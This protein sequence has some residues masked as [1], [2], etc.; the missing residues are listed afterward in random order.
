MGQTIVVKATFLLA[1]GTATLAPEQE[2]ANETDGHWKG[3]SSRSV[4]RPS[5]KV[6]YKPRAEVMLVGHAYAPKKQ[7]VRSLMTR[8]TVGEVDKS[9]EVWCDRV[10]RSQG[11]QLLEGARFTKMPLKWERAAGGPDTNN[12]VGMRFDAAPDAYGAVA[13]PNLQPPG[14]LVSGRSDSF[15]SI[16]FAPIAETWS[17]RTQKLARLAGKFPVPGWEEH[18]LP[19]G[20]DPSF[21]QAAPLDQQ[22]AEIRPNERI[23]LENLHPEHARLVTNLPGLRPKAVVDRATGEHEQVTLVADTLWIDTDRSLCVV[24]WRGTIGLRHAREGGRISV[25]LEGGAA[26]SRESEELQITMPPQGPHTDQHGDDLAMQTM[27]GASVSK[28]SAQ[29]MPFAGAAKPNS[30]TEAIRKIADGVLP[31]GQS[32]RASGQ[33]LPGP[34]VPAPVAAPAVV[35]PAYVPA[36]AIVPPAQAKP[37]SVWASGAPTAAPAAVVPRETIGEAAAAAAAASVM[38]GQSVDRAAQDG[39]LGM[40]NHAANKSERRASGAE[41]NTPA[42]AAAPVVLPARS[43][44]RTADPRDALSLLWFDVPSVRRLRKHKPFAEVLE[45][46]ESTPADPDLDERSTEDL[47]ADVEDRRDV[48]EILARGSSIDAPGVTEALDR[49]IREDGKVIPQLALCAGELVMPFDEVERLKATIATVTPFASSD[50]NLRASL[51]IAKDYLGLPNLSTAPA[52]AEGLTKRILDAFGSSKRT[53]TVDYVDAQTERALLEQRHYQRRKVFGGKHL[54]CLLVLSGSK[55]P[56]PTYLPDA[57]S[58]ELPMYAHF[59]VRLVAE[60]RMA[61][62]QYETHAAALKVVA[63][64]RVVERGKRA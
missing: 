21:F 14:I 42:P 18:P 46:A 3:D 22:V 28:A 25:T 55:D 48:F 13:I 31:F 56:I 27:I 2:G 30:G 23:V 5:D 8:L 63:V 10:W 51:Q 33:P 62:D 59:R 53:V 37:E 32:G 57:L 4:F 50:E 49:S 29:V 24:V 6:P 40:S 44:A 45:Q 52:V 38:A 34:V 60:V 58:E 41:S 12:P 54:R 36:P 16:C 47:P 17:G 15:A 39:A 7:P 64:G 61:E 1:P 19:S 9:I 11:G 43:F 35:P 26:E 20:V